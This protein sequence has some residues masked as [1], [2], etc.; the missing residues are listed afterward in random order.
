MSWL[1]KTVSSILLAGVEETIDGIVRAIPASQCLT[2][3]P[4]LA[5]GITQGE[6]EPDGT[7]PLLRQI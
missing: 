2:A 4:A 3:E 1:R 7:A 6:Q 5:N